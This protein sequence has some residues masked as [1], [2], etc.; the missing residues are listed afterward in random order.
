MA[1]SQLR[2][3]SASLKQEFVDSNITFF[4]EVRVMLD[5]LK[6]AGVQFSYCVHA[7]VPE[8]PYVQDVLY[9]LLQSDEEEYYSFCTA[10]HP[11]YIEN[12]GLVVAAIAT[13]VLNLR[14]YDEEKVH[15]IVAEAIIELCPEEAACLFNHA[16][17]KAKE[18]AGH[19]IPDQQNGDELRQSCGCSNCNQHYMEEVA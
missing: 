8:I 3:L 2:L 10:N 11:P 6:E 14:P 12:I 4:Q 17:F 18:T 9:V 1:S 5:K 13:K 16:F 19:E 7:C 15:K